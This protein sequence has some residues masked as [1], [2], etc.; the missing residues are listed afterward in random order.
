MTSKEILVKPNMTSYNRE[1]VILL[2]KT[3]VESGSYRFARQTALTWL[4]AFPGDL[5]INVWYAKALIKEERLSH[6][7]PVIEKVL[8]T[9]PENLLA[10]QTADEIF[11]KLGDEQ[12]R[13]YRGLVQALGGA[14]SSAKDLPAWAPKLFLAN[15]ALKNEDYSHASALIYSVLGDPDDPMLAGVY[16]LRLTE[17]QSDAQTTLNLAKIYHDRWPECVQI[18]LIYAKAMLSLGNEEE[19]VYLLHQCASADSAAQVPTRMWG[20]QF[21]FKPLYP[22]QMEIPA[23]F[24]IPA[25]VA[26][27]LGFNALG[28]G[29]GAVASAEP[30]G[31]ATDA[32]AFDGYKVSQASDL[33]EMRTPSHEGKAIPPRDEVTVAVEK[34]FKKIAEKL[35]ST[36]STPKDSRFPAYVL[37]STRKGLENQFGIQSAQVVISEMQKLASSVSQRNGWSAFVFLPDDLEISGKYG[38]TP[39]DTIDPWKIKLALGDLDKALLKKG[40]M[41]GSV[42][43]VGGDPV[44]PFHKLPNPADDDDAEVP[45]DN[46]YGTLDT[47]YFVSDW[48][49]GRIPGE[50]G[51]DAGLLLEEIRNTIQYH[52][53]EI[54]SENWLNKLIRLLLFWDKAWAQ[55]FS[56]SGYTA[57]VWQRSSLAAFRPLGEG[58]NLALS[59]QGTIP[60]FDLKRSSTAPFSYYNLHGMA[61]SGDWYGQ[62]DSSDKSGGPD[63][64]VALRAEEVSRLSSYSRIVYT[65]ACYGGKVAE[66]TEKQS[67]ALAML[68]VGALGFVGSTTISYG[69]VTTPLI[70]ADLFG[71]LIMKYMRDG[72]N[73]GTA[74]I[75]SKVDFVNEMNHRQGYLDAEDQKTLISFVLYGDPLVAYD[76]YQAMKKSIN[77]EKMHPVAKTVSD[78]VESDGKSISISPEAMNHAKN[79]VKEYLPGIEYADVKISRQI[80]HN[81]NGAHQTPGT[82]PGSARA[83]RQT[84]RVVVTFSKQVSVLDKN[85]HQYARVTLDPQGKVIKLSLSK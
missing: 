40:E 10:A 52:T 53:D 21:P 24:P 36:Q 48:P 50:A 84:N 68:G 37:L 83:S 85:H 13:V 18:E 73:L 4:A 30:N 1:H 16:H 69:S 66:K 76:P 17:G 27:K 75:K 15:N 38:I 19:A 20:P 80:I 11:S 77:R 57:A 29:S 81:G 51:T 22:T 5:E 70:G 35:K 71:Y 25:E 65:E 56:N 32:R 55:Q 78:T 14:P 54:D 72:V 28:T 63:F 49:V 59:P 7:V 23:N 43:I 6:A 9:D 58:R 12:A 39:V 67:M 44:V 31:K 82:P 74:F 33:E 41:I 34:E 64:P 3:A 61:E 8:H 45:S 46:P 62:K 26:G 60:A 79:M 47:N 42:L 2:V